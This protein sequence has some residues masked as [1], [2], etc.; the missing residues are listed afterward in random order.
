MTNGIMDLGSIV[1][2]SENEFIAA[3]IED[4]SRV[5]R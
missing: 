3:G 5:I 1:G 4:D 2:L